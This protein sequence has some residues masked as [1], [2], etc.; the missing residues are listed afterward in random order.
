MVQLQLQMIYHTN[1]IKN[2]HF[3]E[4]CTLLQWSNFCVVCGADFTGGTSNFPTRVRRKDPP[5]KWAHVTSHHA[6]ATAMSHDV[7]PR[8][9]RPILLYYTTTAGIT[10]LR[11]MPYTTNTTPLTKDDVKLAGC[12]KLLV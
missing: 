4:V 5:P 2:L 1:N 10:R 3:T 6:R 8:L 9:Q 11:E 7:V 12:I